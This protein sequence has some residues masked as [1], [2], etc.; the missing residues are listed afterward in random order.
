MKKCFRILISILI[1]IHI[2]KILIKKNNFKNFLEILKEIIERKEVEENIIKTETIEFEESVVEKLSRKGLIKNISDNYFF[3]YSGERVQLAYLDE[4]KKL[5]LMINSIFEIEDE[6]KSLSLSLDKNKIYVCLSGKKVIKILNCDLANGI[7]EESKKEIIADELHDNDEFADCIEITDNLLA[8]SEEQNQLISIWDMDNCTKKMQILINK[9]T[10]ELLYINSD[11]FVSSQ[12]NFGSITFHSIKNLEEKHTIKI[13]DRI[14]NKHCLSSNENYILI[15][16]TD[17]FGIISI[18]NKELIQFIEIR[19]Y[20]GKTD[21]FVIGNENLIY[22]LYNN[23]D[24]D[25]KSSY[26]VYFDIIKLKDPEMKII[27]KYKMKYKSEKTES[28][29]EIF[30]YQDVKILNVDG[31]ILILDDKEKSKED[32][33]SRSSSDE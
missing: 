29:Y 12:P 33:I 2:I 28:N 27:K 21:Y 30:L 1:I 11:Y 31:K 4:E 14:K 13:A 5:V 32:E 10:K 25:F 8:T 23:Y 16:C 24:D 3:I 22:H 6:I 20:I 19:P 18:K 7:K 17:G 26:E 15:N 9:R